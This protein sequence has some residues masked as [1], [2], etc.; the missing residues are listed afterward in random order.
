MTYGITEL[1]WL[2]I[3]KYMIDDI[4][5]S[6]KKAWNCAICFALLSLVG[7]PFHRVP[8]IQRRQRWG[9]FLRLPILYPLP[10]SLRRRW[11]TSNVPFSH[12]E[13][14]GWCRRAV[15]W[16]K[17]TLQWFS[18]PGVSRGG[19]LG[20]GRRLDRTPGGWRQPCCS[21]TSCCVSKLS[22]KN[23]YYIGE[24]LESVKSGYFFFLLVLAICDICFLPWDLQL[25]ST[26]S[27][28]TL[29]I[30]F[31]V[32]MLRYLVGVRWV[33][34]GRGKREKAVGIFFFLLEI[35]LKQFYSSWGILLLSSLLPI[36]HFFFFTLETGV[37]RWSS[38]QVVRCFSQEGFR[39][40]GNFCFISWFN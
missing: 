26:P 18:G 27:L 38:I 22:S 14:R 16:W 15:L 4:F 19:F 28:C 40:T 24:G 32:G 8:V 34:S 31:Y 21:R 2:P 25:Q 39:Y 11:A 7:N 5:N 13:G 35:N 20:K 17:P 30:Y 6:P 12:F 37:Q 33:V 9:L 36:L 29:K 3:S 1:Q 10:T 23:F